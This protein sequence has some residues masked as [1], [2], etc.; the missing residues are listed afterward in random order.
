MNVIISNRYSE[1]LTNLNI[2][3]IK[4]VRGEYEPEII[5]ANFENFFF[6]KMILD[7]TAVTGYKNITNIQKLASGLDMNKVILLLDDS[8]EV[9]SPSYL[10]GLVSMGIYNFTRN[11]DSIEYLINNPNTY[12]DVAHLHIIGDN[13]SSS[14]PNL[15]INI[16]AGSVNSNFFNE[17]I[18][19]VS[20]GSRVIAIKNVTEH[21]GA[22][23]L[24]YML[25]KQLERNYKVLAIEVDKND[26]VYFNDSDLRTCNTGELDS[27]I[28][29]PNSNYDVIL[30]DINESPKIASI[31]EVI[32]LIEPST[33]KLNKLIRKDRAVLTKMKNYK[34][35]LNKSLLS[36]KDVSEFEYE[37]RCSIFESIPPLDDKKEQN[38]ILNN[39]L[40]KLGFNKQEPVGG[41]KKPV[42]KLFG[43][44][45]D[46]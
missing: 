16:S 13:G 9:N 5:I 14:Q 29:N 28:K 42:G 12:K 35:V 24:I 18:N 3:I 45:K 8:P 44:V 11:I 39:L 37:S 23:T 20:M 41:V 30:V 2:D 4:N 26:F 10:S 27:I 6:N 19:R 22:T 32:H 38:P 7:I 25:K 33:I 15:N 40:N 31:K 21:A 46:E 17:S 43:I 34:I 36:S 1:M